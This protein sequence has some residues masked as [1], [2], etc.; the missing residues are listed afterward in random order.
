M[1]KLYLLFLLLWLVSGCSSS[2][3]KEDK[4]KKED[5]II[6]VEVISVSQVFFPL[7][8]VTI[9]TVLPWREVIITPKVAG[10]IEKILVKEGDLVK[11][12]DLLV[13][14]EEND[15]ILGLKQ[16]EAALATAQAN[17]ANLL[18][19]TRPEKIE[20]AKAALHQAEANLANAE[21]EY[22]RIK[23]L[24]AIEAVAQRQLDAV[25]AQYES[26]VAQVKQAKEQLEMFQRGPTKEEIEVAQAQ[27]KQAEA[28][29][30]VA[31]NYLR[32]SLIKAPFS[33]FI[34][35]RFV[36]EGVQVYTAPKTDILKLTDV[37]QV[38]IEASVPERYYQLIKRGTKGQIKLDALPGKIFS[39][40]VSRIIPEVNQISRNFKVEIDIPNPQFHLK[41]GMFANVI[42]TVGEKKTLAV[43]RD[44]LITEQVTGVTYVFVIEGD[45][46]VQRKLTIGEKSGLWAEV[47]SGLKEG[48][49]LVIKGHT[50][51]K[52]G[53]KVRIVAEAKEGQK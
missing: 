39:G 18:A 52:P 11:A 23:K 38:K 41:S 45:Q 35:A 5:E 43:T 1:K 34:T 26:A 3:S 13:K 4:G 20:Q 8:I 37:H 30:A 33:G 31:Q 53:S 28:T 17:L 22:Q 50:R 51:L 46:A 9:G 15:F 42:L 21:K 7:E 12:G 19:G 40:R 16:A 32:D 49:K 24:A 14:L 48:E 2:S 36:D 44:V 10:K 47:L 29:V 25:T 6:P 27:V